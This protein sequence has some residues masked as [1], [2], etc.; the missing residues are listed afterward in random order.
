MEQGILNLDQVRTLI[1]DEA[2][3]MLDMGFINDIK[4]IVAATPKD[5]QT[6]CFSATLSDGVKIIMRD[7]MENPELVSVKQTE[8]NEHIYQDVVSYENDEAK[9]SL[10][11]DMLKQTEYSK[12]IVF[13]ETKFGVQRLSDRLEASGVASRAIHGNKNQGQ[14]NRALASFKAD[15]VKVLVATDVA[16]RGLD[17]PNVSHV[18]NFDQPQSYSDYVHRIGRTGRGGKAGIALTFVKA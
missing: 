4:F 3:R 15:E 8:S 17:I 14:R 10:L 2:D 11:I 7:F 6:L 9:K 18:I 13:G 1:L 12:V 5:R 16:A